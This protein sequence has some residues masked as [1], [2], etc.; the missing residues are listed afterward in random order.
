MEI[1]IGGQFGVMTSCLT[2]ITQIP[3]GAGHYEQAQIWICK[4]ASGDGNDLDSESGTIDDFQVL[5]VPE[6]ELQSCRR[7]DSGLNDAPPRGA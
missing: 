1:Q 5:L 4:L 3:P 6:I 7:D 2:I